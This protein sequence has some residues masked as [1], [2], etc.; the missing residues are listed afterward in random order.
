MSTGDKQV[1]FSFQVDESSVRSVTQAFEA[2]ASSAKEMNKELANAGMS[3][4]MGGG[5]NTAK[6][7]GTGTASKVVQQAGSQVSS[8]SIKNISM[9]GAVP[10][11][12]GIKSVVDAMKKA[13]SDIES[14]LGTLLGSIGQ[15]AEAT[16]DKL[17]K[18]GSS[19]GGGGR[20]TP[21]YGTA[22]NAVEEAGRN[23]G[24]GGSIQEAM[25]RADNSSASAAV[26]RQGHA[27]PLMEGDEEGGGGGRGK[28]SFDRFKSGA[29][30][31]VRVAGLA[32]AGVQTISSEIVAGST[33]F[34]QMQADRT[35]SARGSF[36][37]LWKGQDLNYSMAVT[38]ALYDNQNQQDTLDVAMGPAAA[39]K[40]GAAAL[41]NAGKGVV[42]S[43]VGGGGSGGRGF[44]TGMMS[45]ALNTQAGIDLQ[46][47]IARI[48]QSRPLIER[49]SVEAY[50]SKQGIR[51]AAQIMLGTGAFK[52]PRGDVDTFA[53]LERD[54]ERQ[55]FDVGQYMGGVGMMRGQTGSGA[56]GW[57]AMSASA[58]GG[59]QFATLMGGAARA[60]GNEQ[61]GHA[62]AKAALGGG[63]NAYAGLGLGASLIGSGFDPMGTTSGLGAI[64][65]SQAGFDWTGGTADF[66]MAQ[67]VGLGMQMSNSIFKGSTDGYQKGRN[68]VDI[69]SI[70]PGAGIQAQDMWANDVNAKQL[71]DIAS[72]LSGPTEYMRQLGNAGDDF[73]GTAKAKIL[74]GVSSIADRYWDDPNS[75]STMSVNM[76]TMTEGGRDPLDY[77]RGMKKGKGRNDMAKSLIAAMTTAQGT[78]EENAGTVGLALGVGA[79]AFGSG[80]IGGGLKKG[81]LEHEQGKANADRIEAE[82]VALLGQFDAIK[83]STANTIEQAKA[84]A[85]WGDNL[86]GEMQ[87]FIVA[88]GQATDALDPLGAAA[89]TREA[90]LR[91]KVAGEYTTTEARPA[92]RTGTTVRMGGGSFRR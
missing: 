24:K 89:R 2:I 36:N 25:S 3:G 59:G 50:Q 61:R 56:L 41:M 52:G 10:G 30:A 40:R 44:F 34:Q 23:W 51:R 53:T 17:K 57:A 77:L 42:S 26:T 71:Y 62:I 4:L 85:G 38:S 33:G 5:V 86:N 66:N 81:S 87:K 39:V 49:Q 20:E 15:K 76:R 31:A 84:F 82:R 45:E 92:P 48:D 83:K 68:L 1:K 19:V 43:A 72:G 8:T 6:A 7:D 64:A 11:I 78:W 70:M 13:A 46:A 60:V 91:K 21:W 73:K 54:L 28:W 35:N 79:E 88:L 75:T 12:D 14:S 9:S 47:Q 55:G 58:V 74:A 80:N 65:A 27:G 90:E 29:M 67:R 69:M 22:V 16:T 18:M 32:F 63:I 37:R